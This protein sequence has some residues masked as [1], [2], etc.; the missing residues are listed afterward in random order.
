M[1]DNTLMSK[2]VLKLLKDNYSNILFDTTIPRSTEASKSTR[3]KRILCLDN[4]KL[5][6]AYKNLASE[7]LSK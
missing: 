2:E 7:M 5:G 6:K 4:T 3:N 1:T